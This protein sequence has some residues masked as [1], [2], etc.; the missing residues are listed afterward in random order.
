MNICNRTLNA[1]C[2]ILKREKK[3]R[4]IHI[5]TAVVRVDIIHGRSGILGDLKPAFNF[6]VRNRN[7][8][9]ILQSL[10]ETALNFQMAMKQGQVG[11]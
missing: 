4:E 2:K 7:P 8:H 11:Q 6:T 9:G 3:C 10:G 5:K 1:T